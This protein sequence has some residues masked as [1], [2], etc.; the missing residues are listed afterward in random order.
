MSW[1]Y[2][3]ANP[4]PID[5]IRPMIGD[6]YEAQPIMS[7]EEIMNGLIMTSTQNLYQNSTN[8]A[9]GAISPASPTTGAIQV[10]SLWYAAAWCLDC[11]ASNKAFL[12]SIQQ[13]LDVKLDAS[14]ACTALRALAKDYRDRE[15]NAGHFAM[16]EQVTNAFQA[17]QRWWH[18]LLIQEGGS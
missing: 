4:G 18:Q 15:D 11:M 3:P 7:N 17:R 13:L 12:S 5:Y 2:N 1:S 14:K 16:I 9:T 10:Y 6:T 8:Y